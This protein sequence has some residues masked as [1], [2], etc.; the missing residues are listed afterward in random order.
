[1]RKPGVVLSVL[2]A[3]TVLVGAAGCSSATSSKSSVPATP[4]SPSPTIAASCLAKDPAAAP[5]VTHF[6]SSDG[7]DQVE[8]YTL[9]DGPIGVVLAHQS[10]DDLCQWQPMMADFTAKSYRVMAISMGD[11][12][13]KDVVAAAAQ[14]RSQGSTK[15]VLIGASM[16]GTAVLGAAPQTMPPVS[17]V[18]SLSGPEFYG[19]ADALSAVKTMTVPVSFFVAAGD[20]Q[21]ADAAHALFAAATEKDKSIKVLIGSSHGVGLWPLVKDDVFTFIA[22]VTG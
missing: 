2:L 21:F 1:M 9:G 15:I 12:I 8:A 18:V 7:K 10:G 11:R 20:T 13:D 5:H 4:S 3:A 16:G 19:S 22:K 17:G 14:L 6:L